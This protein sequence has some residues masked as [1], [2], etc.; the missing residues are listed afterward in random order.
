MGGALA[1]IS[2][3]IP[4]LL[5]LGVNALY[6]NPIFASPS[7]H[8]YD[9]HDYFRLDRHIGKLRT[10]Q[11]MLH[12]HARKTLL[13]ALFGLKADLL[14]RPNWCLIRDNRPISNLP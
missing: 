5:D 1:G 9:T 11:Q 2:A 6:L 12:H 13:I 3:K 8:H 10:F 14:Q 4:Y 7:T